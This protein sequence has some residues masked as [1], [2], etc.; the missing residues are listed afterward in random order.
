MQLTREDGT[1][2]RISHFRQKQGKATAKV[3]VF[4]VDYPASLAWL[5][6]TVDLGGT[7]FAGVRAIVQE[8]DIYD[9]QEEWLAP[10]TTYTLALVFAKDG[11]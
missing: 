11:E 9:P 1:T 8:I 7:V 4:G 6:C 2:Y 5:N 10:D 3:I